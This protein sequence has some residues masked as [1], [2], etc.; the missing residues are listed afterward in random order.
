MAARTRGDAV[1][2]RGGAALYSE[3]EPLSTTYLLQFRCSMLDHLGWCLGGEGG[4]E[5]AREDE[6]QG[7]A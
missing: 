1:D 4:G 3:R 6:A 7:A 5:L 2:A